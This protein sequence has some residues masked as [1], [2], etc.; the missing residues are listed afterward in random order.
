MIE[1]VRA[2]ADRV[3]RS[4]KDEVVKLTKEN[5]DL[6]VPPPPPPSPLSL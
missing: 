2:S 4:L 3:E 1:T 5:T 6:R